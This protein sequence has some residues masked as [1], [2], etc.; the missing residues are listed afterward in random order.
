MEASQLPADRFHAYLEALKVVGFPIV[1]VGV[2]V[3]W[4]AGWMP[5]TATENNR[6]IAANN[7]LIKDTVQ[8]YREETSLT[9]VAIASLRVE[10]RHQ[11][12]LAMCLAFARTPDV[13]RQ[14]LEK[15]P[16]VIQPP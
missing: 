8:A 6:L 2:F 14:C 3:A 15:Y 12:N 9:R 7:Q 4:Q 11:M 1:M 10:T 5:S 13:Q 16:V